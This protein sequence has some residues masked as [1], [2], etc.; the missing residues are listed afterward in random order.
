MK[1]QEVNPVS[2]L[3]RLTTDSLRGVKG[4]NQK[5]R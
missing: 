4:V 2:I 3:Q 1:I 5:T